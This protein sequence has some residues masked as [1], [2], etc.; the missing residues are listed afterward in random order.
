MMMAAKYGEADIRLSSG[1]W[2]R[3]TFIVIYLE[4]SARRVQEESIHN[5]HGIEFCDG[6][7][8]AGIDG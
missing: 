5:L 4:L 7:W 1:W 2:P 6:E 8:C 3:R